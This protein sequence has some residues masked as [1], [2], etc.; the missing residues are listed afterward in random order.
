MGLILRSSNTPNP[1]DDIR[2]KNN[3][4]WASEEDGN[5]MYLLTNMSGSQV[6]IKSQTTT[7]TGN[8]NI[9]GHVNVR[10][11]VQVTGVVHATSSYAINSSTSQHIKS[12]NVEGPNGFNSVLNAS[13]ADHASK[14]DYADKVD[15]KTV[16][17]KLI[18]SN[19]RSINGQTADNDGNI[20]ISLLSTKVGTLDEM[21]ASSVDEGTIWII[22]DGTT[23]L[24]KSNKWV[25]I[26]SYNQTATDQR[27]LKLTGGTLTGPLD[28]NSNDIMDAETISAKDILSTDIT[29]DNTVTAKEFIGNLTGIA[30][31][32]KLSSN[33][34]GGSSNHISLW[35]DNITLTNSNIF[36]DNEGNIG[37]GTTT[38]QYKLDVNGNSRFTDIIIDNLELR[39]TDLTLNNNLG[40]NGGK[41]SINTTKVDSTLN[42]N[43]SLSVVGLKDNTKHTNVLNVSGLGGR[44]FGIDTEAMSTT[45]SIKLNNSTAYKSLELIAGA[46]ENI[47]N[48]NINLKLQ[49]SNTL[50][51]QK[52]SST[53]APLM[54]IK[55]N[56]SSKLEV[57]PSSVTINTI[58]E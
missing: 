57:K 1:T 53:S 39:D 50:I 45:V 19:V 47:I 34:E 37:I 54:V 21:N 43:E 32:A 23:Y 11:N 48:S 3:T 9:I 4:L 24:G 33:I 28:M 13:H 41:V 17:G 7:I 29:A 10:G 46:S 44:I 40:I 25:K 55:D 52:T 49:Q 56:T 5:L 35:K 31:K 14:S 20:A 36:Q 42:V 58:L 6:N 2:I 12:S 18:E 51:I 30:D 38:P 8:T 15:L 26:P 16:S 27:Y 22:T